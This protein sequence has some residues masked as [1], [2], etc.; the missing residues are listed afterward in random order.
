[1]RLAKLVLSPVYAACVI[2]FRLHL[3]ILWSPA[4]S[5]L[6]PPS[7]ERQSRADM[8]LAFPLIGPRHRK[9]FQAAIRKSDGTPVIRVQ[10]RH[11]F[12]RAGH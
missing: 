3:D 12:A 4:S 10:S 7:R 8:S 5:S 2:P 6:S 11:L 9:N 1:M